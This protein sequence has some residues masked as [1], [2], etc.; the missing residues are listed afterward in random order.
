MQTPKP[1]APVVI[2]QTASPA[3]PRPAPARSWATG[4]ARF[5]TIE[6]PDLV[7]MVE[8]Q[9]QDA[10]LAGHLR[11]GERI[12]EADLA[13]RMDISRAPVRE[14]ARRL[15]SMGLLI[16]RPRHGFAVRTISSRE[17][18][19]LYQVRIDLELL[20][21]TLA[22]QQA[23]DAQLARLLPMVDH[24]AAQA[25][26]LAQ[27]ER[28]ALDLGF[29]CYI[30]EISGNGYLHR[31]F[32]NMQAE[33]RLFLSLSEA[34]YEDPVY[35]AETHRPIAQ[36]L[37]ARDAQ[38]VRGALR[39]HLEVAQ[40]HARACVEQAGLSQPPAAASPPPPRALADA[41]APARAG[42][43]GNP[44]PWKPIR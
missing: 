31:L 28:V 5:S 26:R 41:D 11:P 23:T 19:D 6:R 24:M 42:D 18:D 14:A 38:T 39:Y 12:V 22:C 27:S 32:D 8:A 29:H 1:P 4:N 17:V 44:S 43:T 30:S 34:S 20:G 3:L 40:Q 2:G 37:A 25:T 21:A 36:A 10:I 13:R 33:V 16:S 15:E 9:I 35:L 7:A